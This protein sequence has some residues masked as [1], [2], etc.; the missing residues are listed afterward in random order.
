MDQFKNNLL[1][2]RNRL[3]SEI[4][5]FRFDEFNKKPDQNNWSAAQVCDHLILVEI[6]FT[7]AIIYGM[8]KEDQEIERKDLSFTLDRK[9]KIDAPEIV[10]PD[11]EQIEVQSV[12]ERLS[13]SRKE[14]LTV[15]N[16]IKDRSILTGKYARHPIFGKIPLDQ[17]IELLY[18]HEQRHIE[19]IREIKGKIGVGK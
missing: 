18:L 17:W 16:T 1:E 9:Q 19:Q 8:R 13:E 7:K 2:T 12:L 14:L 5:P 10:I 3:L 4:R 6:A 11:S 15:L